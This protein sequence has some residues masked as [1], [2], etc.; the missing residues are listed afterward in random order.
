MQ[1]FSLFRSRRARKYSQK[2]I[3]L[4]SHKMLDISLFIV[5]TSI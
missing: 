2:L 1:A 5:Y 3:Q 4:T